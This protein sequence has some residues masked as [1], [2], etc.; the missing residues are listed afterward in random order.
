MMTIIL[1][2]SWVFFLWVIIGCANA[3]AL[4]PEGSMPLRKEI[5]LIISGPLGFIPLF[6]DWLI[7]R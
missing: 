3:L 2:L 1:N 7:Q 5:L 6:Y 4:H